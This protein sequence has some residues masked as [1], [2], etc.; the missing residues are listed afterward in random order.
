MKLLIDFLSRPAGEILTRTLAALGLIACSM[1]G[2]QAN[3]IAL[4]FTGGVGANTSVD[5][6]AG[7]GFS[8]TNPI[9]LTD[10]GLW[11]A[12]NSSSA[13]VGDGLVQSHLVTVWTSAGT[14]LAQ[15]TIPAG[16]GAA[17]TNG[18]RYIPLGSSILL[19]VGNYII[20]GFFPGN[21]FDDFAIET[22]AVSTASGVTYTGSQFT[23][24]NGFPSPDN[25]TDRF[26][27]PNF[28]FTNVT[29]VPDEGST[30]VLL[31]LGVMSLIAV[32]FRKRWVMQSRCS[33]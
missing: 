24:A 30:C 22:S 13:T 25:R 20:G 17:L 27:G 33:Y 15:V 1:G 29:T 11:D 26:F 8:L 6:T 10:L 19:P 18:F 4:S 7:W 12:P 32:N 5:A 3:T 28:Q 23:H 14:Q 21:G 2:A 31:M 9:A 16:S